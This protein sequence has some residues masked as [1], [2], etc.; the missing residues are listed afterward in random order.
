MNVYELSVY[1]FALSIT[2][3][4]ILGLQEAFLRTEVQRII[5]KATQAT[6]MTTF[7]TATP[8]VTDL[9]GEQV[10]LAKDG[11]LSEENISTLSNFKTVLECPSVVKANESFS[12]VFREFTVIDAGV[13]IDFLVEVGLAPISDVVL[14]LHDYFYQGYA[15]ND[16]NLSTQDP[17]EG[18][19]L[20][21]EVFSGDY[22]SQ[23]LDIYCQSYDCVS[24]SIMDYISFIGCLPTYKNTHFYSALKITERHKIALSLLNLIYQLIPNSMLSETFK[25]S[26]H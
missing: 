19:L 12:N 2:Q 4:S 21:V 14:F 20:G 8:A 7:L 17:V 11:H 25:G 13:K 5:D 10:G 9:F 22:K 24:P 26:L 23:A 18:I 15:L 3:K 1:G 16:L 6:Y